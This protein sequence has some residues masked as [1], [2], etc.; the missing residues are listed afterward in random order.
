MLKWNAG[1][2][3]IH[4]NRP[5]Y[6]TFRAERLATLGHEVHAI[7]R[8]FAPSTAQMN[9]VPHR[10][11]CGSSRLA[12]AAAAE[13]T[14]RALPLD[15][16][17]DNGDGW[18]GDVLLPHSGIR[19]ALIEQ[20]M[21]QAPRWWRA[22][23]LASMR[24]LPR[25]ARFRELGA[26]QYGN[27][28]R[29]YLAIS[30]M[31]ADDMQRHHHV[32]ASQ[33]RLVYNGIDV[34][35]F[36]PEQCAPHRQAIRQRLG[37]ADNEVLLLIVAVNFHRKGVPALL[38]A[39]ANLHRQGMPVRLAVVGGKRLAPWRRQAARLGLDRVATFVGHVGDPRP[40]YG[41]ADVYVMPTL[42]DPCS[43][44]VLE[45][46]SAG[47]PVVTSRFNGAG[48]MLT[49]GTDGDVLDDPTDDARLAQLLRPYFD[50]QRL[51]TMR[52]AARQTALRHSLDQNCREILAVYEE[53]LTS[54]RARAA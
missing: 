30:R 49:P 4:E 52:L 17:H 24:W 42:Y 1:W 53:I 44:V 23:K 15:I 33:I 50:A 31:I 35:K 2:G 22:L 48:E 26:R 19:Q 21:M 47:V 14:A 39:T 12:F 37:V 45:A 25:Y 40:Y 34:D 8:D 38:R 7:A 3:H 5:G 54:R 36:A 20:Q 6:R 43:L 32:P 10:V 41:A 28:E 16:V 29:R 13:Q 27:L 46:L 51:A 18:Y 9:V 11:A